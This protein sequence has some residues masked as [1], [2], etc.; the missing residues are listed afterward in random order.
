MPKKEFYA[1]YVANA[2]YTSLI[3]GGKASCTIARSDTERYIATLLFDMDGINSLPSSATINS[4]SLEYRGCTSRALVYIGAKFQKQSTPTNI[5]FNGNIFTADFPNTILDVYEGGLF[6]SKSDM[7]ASK[8]EDLNFPYVQTVE[9][10]KDGCFVSIWAY[11]NNTSWDCT[12]T[13]D[14]IKIV[15]DYILPDYYVAK[16]NGV[17][18]SDGDYIA[19]Q[20]NNIFR[21]TEYQASK[22]EPATFIAQSKVGGEISKVVCS[23]LDGELWSYNTDQLIS[24]GLLSIQNNR[25][26]FYAT[27][28]TS[29]CTVH[30]YTVYFSFGSSVYIGDILCY[31]YRGDKLMDV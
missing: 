13:I 12:L 17:D 21:G 2:N 3:D 9:S 16:I 25:H 23:D 15:V 29:K 8:I 30:T 24:L 7:V 18:M 22:N 27:D 20:T 19:I 1:K 26:Y 10:L 5:S 4:I 14:N 28:I 31:L 6:T 11:M